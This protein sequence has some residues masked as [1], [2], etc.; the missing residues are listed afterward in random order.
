M[1]TTLTSKGQVTIPKRIR[2]AMHLMPGSPVEFSVNAAGEVVLHPARPAG[3]AY[4]PT[5]DRFD[6]VRGRSDVPWRTD[7]LMKLL[8]A[9]D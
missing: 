6:A 4:T 1:P 7:E 8:R 9:D 2:D 5:R 3:S